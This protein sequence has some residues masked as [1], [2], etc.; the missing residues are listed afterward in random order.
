[1]QKCVALLQVLNDSTCFGRMRP[2]S[3]VIIF[4]TAAQWCSVS[5]KEKTEFVR[6]SVEVYVP[7]LHVRALGADV[8]LC[9]W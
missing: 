2:S 9:W 7:L 4:A 3:G 6:Y 8:C 1:M 5:T